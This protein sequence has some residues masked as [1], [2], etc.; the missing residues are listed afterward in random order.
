MRYS[1]SSKPNLKKIAALESLFEFKE[2]A[3]VFSQEEF[4][5]IAHGDGVPTGAIKCQVD[6][7]HTLILNDTAETRF[8]SYITKCGYASSVRGQTKRIDYVKPWANNPSPY[9]PDFIIHDYR[10]RIVFVEIKSIL[11]MCQDENIAKMRALRGYCLQN[12]FLF[13][14]LDAEM[15]PFNEYLVPL[16]EE[17]DD[18]ISYFYRVMSEVGGFTTQHLKAYLL[19]HKERKPSEIKRAFAK[20]VL[21]DPSLEDRYCH[22]S[23]YE[24]NVTE[25][26]APAAFKNFGN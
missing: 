21:Q 25:R 23:P 12:R 13:G 5:S 8:L 17:D 9:Y 16:G 3:A 1:F 7:G 26:Q 19:K 6:N 2:N 10:G 18:V 14:F 20:I 4:E 15:E 22:D 11:G 24:I